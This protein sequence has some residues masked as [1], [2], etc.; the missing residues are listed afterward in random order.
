MAIP[1]S[2]Y[3]AINSVVGGATQ[4]PGREFIARLF[5]TNPL[6]PPSSYV[7]FSSLSS[8]GDYFG[9]DSQEYKRAA[10]YFSYFSKN[11]TAATKIS[12][13][14]WVDAATQATVFGYV[15]DVP[16]SLSQYSS[17]SNG[18][19][20]LTFNGVFHAFTALDFTAAADL[21]GVATVL[22]TAI[23]GT[24]AGS[25]VTFN[26]AGANFILKVGTAV[27]STLTVQAGGTGTDLSQLLNW[28]PA[29]PITNGRFIPGQN[30]VGLRAATVY[31]GA[32]AETPV[33]ALTTS[34]NLSTNFGSFAFMPKQLSLT[35]TAGSS[36]VP[37][38]DTSGLTVGMSVE[39]VGV[40][41]G[42]VIGVVTANTSITLG[43]ASAP[44]TPVLATA[45]GAQTLS[46]YL[47]LAQAVA[48]ATFNK[49]LN[50]VYEYQLSVNY[51]NAAIWQAGLTGISGVGISLG[52]GVANEY[53]EM[54][55]M[56]IQAA[57]DYSKANAVVNYEFQQAAG[58]SPSV[59][60]LQAALSYNNIS[61][62]YYG[63]TQSAGQLI[64]F[65]QQGVLQGLIS[66]PTD[67]NTYANEIW[68]KDAMGAAFLNLLLG[69]SRVPAN[70]QGRAMLLT[71]MATVINQALVNGTISVGKTLTTAQIVYIG[72]ITNDENAWREVQ[73][74]GYWRDIVFVAQNT[75]PVTYKASYTLVY[76]KDDVIRKVEGTDVLI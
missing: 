35:L 53:I 43:L 76:S 41:D 17:I 74:Q 22:Q 7:E 42:T 14:R 20:G 23:S 36:V 66:D 29:A 65:Y 37:T 6:L 57:T 67:M 71:I 24:F 58:L 13:A 18:S 73:N 56:A 70:S 61:V 46:F 31:G 60:T 51:G 48:V 55:P 72:Q 15:D 27:A 47:S 10:F 59:T 3:V 62:N 39:G 4:I 44:A 49:S 26:A 11:G 16:Q 21:A 75:L 33:Q 45:S 52:S 25:T 9:T 8:V 19:I 40:P 64:N 30:V 12:Y 38:S 5:T 1:Q 69:V 32:V 2:Q 54:L 34:N 50:V 28:L 68:L 63:Q